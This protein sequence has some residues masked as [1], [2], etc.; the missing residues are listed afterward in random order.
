MRTHR[1]GD[2]GDLL[3]WKILERARRRGLHSRVEGTIDTICHAAHARARTAASSKQPR[4]REAV[5]ICQ[6]R[7]T[8]TTH[9][10][11]PTLD[12]ASQTPARALS[13]RG[14]R[15]ARHARRGS[16]G[17]PP[18]PERRARRPSPGGSHA[19]PRG[20]AAARLPCACCTSPPPPRARGSLRTTQH[21]RSTQPPLSSSAAR[22]GARAAGGTHRRQRAFRWC[23]PSTGR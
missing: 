19:S 2:G 20:Q 13:R 12:C 11:R 14:M 18:R 22:A 16:P 4:Q 10:R 21:A 9:K 5:C 8:Q 1:A 17:P 6:C 7:C 23:R 3:H 15:P